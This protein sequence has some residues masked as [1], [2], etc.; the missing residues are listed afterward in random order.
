MARV[1]TLMVAFGLAAWPGASVADF[2]TGR[3]AYEAGDYAIALEEW[4]PLATA[5]DAAR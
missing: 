2:E 3:R 4:A 1:W 5:G